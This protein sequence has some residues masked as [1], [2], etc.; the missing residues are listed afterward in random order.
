L[1]QKLLPEIMR[2]MQDA[3]AR[4][5]MARAMKQRENKRAARTVA[6]WLLNA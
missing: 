5:T 4:D 3:S 1:K 2:L 6:E